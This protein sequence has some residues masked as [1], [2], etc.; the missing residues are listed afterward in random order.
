MLFVFGTCLLVGLDLYLSYHRLREFG[1]LV[2][3][4]PVAREIA[5]DGGPKGAITFL[6]IFNLAILASL[7]YFQLDT[8]L[9]VFFGAKLGLAAMQL[10]SLQLESYIERI[11]QRN[12]NK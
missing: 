1:P 6:G 3:L 7:L 8:W 2:E 5:K 4:N 11:L 9:H 10:K 12:Q